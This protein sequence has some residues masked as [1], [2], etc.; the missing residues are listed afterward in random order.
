MKYWIFSD[1]EWNYDELKSETTTLFCSPDRFD[2][3][4]F[5]PVIKFVKNK[6]PSGQWKLVSDTDNGMA[7]YEHHNKKYSP[8]YGLIFTASDLIYNE[9]FREF[10]KDNYKVNLLKCEPIIER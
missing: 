6:K 10:I 5:E 2:F 7:Y 8:G 3:Q 4:S 9:E 1:K